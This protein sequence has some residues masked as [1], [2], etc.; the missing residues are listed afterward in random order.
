[1]IA[2]AEKSL[3][4]DGCFCFISLIQRYY[5][6]Q[7]LAEVNGGSRRIAEDNGGYRRLLK[8]KTIFSCAFQLKILILVSS[9]IKC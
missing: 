2:D 4:G 9:H 7:R 1:M 3:R 6:G 5:M 8:D